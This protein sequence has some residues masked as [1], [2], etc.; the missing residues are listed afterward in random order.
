MNPIWLLTASSLCLMLGLDA[1]RHISRLDTFLYC[2]LLALALFLFGCFVM[3]LME[4]RQP[5]D[6][7]QP[8]DD[9]APETD[10]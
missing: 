2:L 9:N 1:G 4:S 8:K 6:N 5:A 3:E 10:Q 7:S